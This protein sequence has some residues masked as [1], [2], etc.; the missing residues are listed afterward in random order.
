MKNYFFKIM[1]HYS[2]SGFKIKPSPFFILLLSS[3]F[4]LTLTS[5]SIA[6]EFFGTVPLPLPLTSENVTPTNTPQIEFSQNNGTPIPVEYEYQNPQVSPAYSNSTAINTIYRVEVP[7]ENELLLQSVRAVEP[8]A[9]IRRGEGVIQVGLF[10]NTTN[11]QN[12]IQKLSAQGITARIVQISNSNLATLNTSS[13]N[14]YGEIENE[15][16]FVVIPGEMNLLATLANKVKQSGVPNNVLR[17]R[18][19][20]LGPHVAVG[21]FTQR[22][23]AERWNNH[24]RSAGLDARVYFGH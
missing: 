13:L 12:M 1:L 7:S 22:N 2:I 16:Y 18:A 4:C 19:A 11:A 9:F 20:P 10:Q 24:L 8:T 23:E 3:F 5:K 14:I 6:Q 17:L 15:G 21:P